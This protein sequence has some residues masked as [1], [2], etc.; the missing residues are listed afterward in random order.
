MSCRVRIVYRA[1]VKKLICTVLSVHWLA[2]S[3][4][5]CAHMAGSHH[6]AFES[7][8]VHSA[9]DFHHEHKNA[10]EPSDA[11]DEPESEAGL[12]ASAFSS[13]GDHDSAP[14]ESGP[15][16][17]QDRSSDVHCFTLIMS[18][19]GLPGVVSQVA[20]YTRYES[21]LAANAVSPPVPPPDA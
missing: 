2:L 10:H 8:H 15:E 18:E 14:A 7:M 17:S 5:A 3:A 20:S 9:P 11:L 13:A 6:D 16:P 1:N 4:I 12:A 19:G 21:H